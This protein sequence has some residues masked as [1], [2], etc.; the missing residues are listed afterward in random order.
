MRHVTW[1]ECEQRVKGRTG[2]RFKKAMSASDESAILRS[3]GIDP[4]Q[5]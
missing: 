4:I 1:A 5:M 2:A 3:W